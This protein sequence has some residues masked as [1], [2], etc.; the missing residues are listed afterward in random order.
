MSGIRAVLFD[1]GATLL[2]PDPPVEEVYAREL[3]SEGARFTAGQLSAALERAWIEVRENGTGDRYGGVRGEPG[4][5]RSFLDRLRGSLDGGTVPAAAFGRLAA[6]FRDPASWALYPDV[7]STLDRLA[8]GGLRLAVVSN[9]DS[10]LP[11]LL[12][13]LGLSARFDAVLVSAIEQTGK[14]EPEIFRRACARLSV[15]PAEALHVGDSPRE[16]FEGARAAGLA[17]LLLDRAGRHEG[18]ADRIRSL[19]EVADRL[20]L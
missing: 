14:P 1:A 6:H 16:D 12:S 8:A 5:W 9:W 13:G 7:F 15:A 20:S 2:Y 18:T 3:S 10:Y 17:S 19:A 11:A 4:F